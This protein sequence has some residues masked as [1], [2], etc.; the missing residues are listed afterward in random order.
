MDLQVLPMRRSDGTG[1]VIFVNVTGAE[2]KR[3]YSIENSV[4]ADVIVQAINFITVVV[5][6]KGIPTP[7]IQ[8][9][10]LYKAQKEL[11][12]DALERKDGLLPCTTQTVSEAIGTEADITLISFT[13]SGGGDEGGGGERTRS[14]SSIIGF[15]SDIRQI[16]VAAS[17][18]KGVCL[19]VG[20]YSHIVSAF[21]SNA[22]ASNSSYKALRFFAKLGKDGRVYSSYARLLGNPDKWIEDPAGFY[23]DDGHLKFADAFQLPVPQGGTGGNTT[24]LTWAAN[25]EVYK[26]FS[27]GGK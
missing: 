20:D 1:R 17:R 8:V 12:R 2:K 21:A 7:S 22:G 10:S 4:E 24:T 15:L 23:D 16:T 18:A 26:S 11:I 9:L 19:F 25:E 5:G 13:R 14:P 27:D 3:I 6:N